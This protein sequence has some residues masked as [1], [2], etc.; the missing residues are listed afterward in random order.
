[1]R[2]M[3]GIYLEKMNYT[4]KNKI[5]INKTQVIAVLCMYIFLLILGNINLNSAVENSRFIRLA[6]NQPYWTF[7][8]IT[9]SLCAPFLIRIIG[10]RR[11]VVLGLS[12]SIVTLVAV[13]KFGENINGSVRWFET[14]LGSIQ[15][16]EIAKPV[17]VLFLAYIFHDIQ[18]YK[19][20]FIIN[21]VAT[22]IITVLIAKEDLGTSIVFLFLFTMLY[23]VSTPNLKRFFF[24][25]V[26][27]LLAVLFFFLFGL[28]DY[29]KDRLTAF[30]S[31]ED[32]QD[33]YYQTRQS[34]IMVGSGGIEGKG[35]KRGP[36]NL[37]GFIPADHTD[38]VLSVYAEENGFR[39][40]LIYLSAWMVLL[41]SILVS[42][43]KTT[44]LSR[45]LCAGVFSVL[46]FQFAFNSAMILGLVPVTGLPLPFFTYGGSSMVSNASL[47]G[48]YFYANTI[49]RKYI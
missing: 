31:P 17:M 23:F 34:I 29:Q 11:V 14:P 9:V 15:P 20:A 18:N 41:V 28:E 19:K 16:S 43:L 8:G 21:S 40:M 4:K 48:L 32:N 3:N 49:Q 25:M 22:V 45:F 35:Y 30:M 13:L 6:H 27:L 46:F 7:L 10:L 47:I 38:F 2:R 12:F 24:I 5:L 1:M 42:C 44:A 33:T 37:Y 26:I 36:G 39:G